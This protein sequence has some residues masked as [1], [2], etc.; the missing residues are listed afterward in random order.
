MNLRRRQD[1]S[2]ALIL[3]VVAALATATTTRAHDDPRMSVTVR[4]YQTADLPF[5]LEKRVLAEAE[6]VL[7]GAL[8]DVRWRRCGTRDSS[9]PCVDAPEADLLLRIAIVEAT[10]PQRPPTLGE[11]IVSGRTG[12]V[13]ASVY[14]DRVTA[15][16]EETQSD[17]ALL[18]GRVVAHELGHLMMRTS[19][20][21]ARTGLMRSNWTPEE[22]RRNL[23][24]DWAFTPE[25]VAA[26]RR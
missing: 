2:I 21:H 7:R 26:I 11:A 13:L 19:V 6:R 23:E 22:I 10:R 8:V 12:G 5:A 14:V 1:L 17:V 18:L 4:V 16:A 15:L 20:R 3:A 25:D 24:I 9:S